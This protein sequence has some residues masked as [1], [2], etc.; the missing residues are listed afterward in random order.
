M[1]AINPSAFYGATRGAQDARTEYRTDEAFGLDQAIRKQ[2]LSDEQQN[3][4][5][6]REAAALTLKNEQEQAPLRRQLLKSRIDIAALD[7]TQRK[8]LNERMTEATGRA[9]TL[10]T[11]LAKFHMTGE[12]QGVADAI[13]KLYPDMDIKNP[14]AERNVDGSITF[15]ADGQ[16]SKTFKAGVT[17]EGEEYT[18]ED[19]V[20]MYAFE[21]L[22]PVKIEQAKF[23]ADLDAKAGRV[24]TSQ[25]IKQSEGTEAAKAKGKEGKGTYTVPQLET[26]VKA[27]TTLVE[28]AVKTKTGLGA[29]VAGFGNEEDK[30][31]SG[32]MASRAGALVRGPEQMDPEKASKKVVDDIR[33]EFDKVKSSINEAAEKLW[34]EGVDAANEAAIQKAASSGNKTAARLQALFKLAGERLGYS[35]TRGIKREIV[36]PKRLRK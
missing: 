18:A 22:D 31:L 17:P 12:P 7:E 4:P 5:I 10:N 23:Q 6:R 34:A 30:E 3:S 14:K 27:A 20:S 26:R 19:A 32:V 9:K 21:A 13:A 28:K 16:K 24:K 2:R 8:D 29:M 36:Q 1:G 25:A 35:V 33:Y 15:S 11:A